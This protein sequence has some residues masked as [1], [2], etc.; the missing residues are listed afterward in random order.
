[1]DEER[2]TKDHSAAVRGTTMR[3]GINHHSEKSTRVTAL[4]RRLNSSKQP[5]APEAARPLKMLPMLL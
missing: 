2:T 4:T 1:M 3:D 5:Q